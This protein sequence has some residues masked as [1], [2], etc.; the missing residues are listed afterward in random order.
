MNG[1]ISTPIPT[2][3]DS[4]HCTTKR[5]L[6]VLDWSN[7][8]YRSLFVSHLFG[9]APGGAEM[10]FDDEH[11]VQ[12]F[13]GKF[14]LDVVNILRMFRPTNTVI[15]VDDSHPWRKE[16]LP[17]ENGYKGNRSK[18]ENLNWDN[19]YR[20]SNDLLGLF[21]DKGCHVAKTGNAEADDI[22]TLCKE[23]VFTSYPD[24]NVIVV[25]SD[26]DL[27]QLIDFNPITHQYC[28]VFNTITR[29]KTGKRYFYLTQSMYDW[30]CEPNITDIFFS[31][32]DYGKQYLLDLF[33]NNPTTETVVEN[34]NDVVLGKI[35]CGDDSD[36][37]PAFYEW[38]KDG[39]KLRITPTRYQKIVE[40]LEIK[41]IRDLL[42]KQN[43]LTEQVSK[44]AKRVVGDLDGPE[45]VE[46]QR[47]LVELNSGLFPEHIQEYRDVISD[48][49]QDSPE[50]NVG[51]LSVGDVLGVSSYAQILTERPEERG[52]D[53]DFF[54][55]MKDK[56][57][58][59]APPMTKPVFPLF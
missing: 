54:S 51:N 24:Y 40:T 45:R 27:R 41:N 8:L 37:V 48:M 56:M 12:Q 7:L 59:P 47:K 43:Y 38:Y 29:P 42:N 22:V 1:T 57:E 31:S 36:N 26:A 13:V 33:S 6:L 32:V 44:I 46:R 4:T 25:S 53:A 15:A 17:K 52:M 34:P 18:N 30:L 3:V 35:F 2:P 19:I 21:R 5:I 9:N 10:T 16:L 23:T 39:R 28:A 50:T 11:Q 49:I 58:I 55:R 14:T 20:A